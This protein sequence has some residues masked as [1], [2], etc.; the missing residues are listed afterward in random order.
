MIKLILR[1]TLL[2][3]MLV[4]GTAIANADTT[5]SYTTLGCFGLG[6]VPVALDSEPIAGPGSLVFAGVIIPAVV[7][8]PTGGF[9][10]AQLG[11]FTWVGT[12]NGAFITPFTLQIV[13]TLP[14]GGSD[15]F[16]ATVSG[17]V[18]SISGINSTTNVIFDFTSVT[19]GTVTYQLTNLGGPGTAGPTSLLINPPGQ[20]TTLQSIVTVNE[21]PEPASMLLLGT[22]LLGAAGAV[23]RRFKRN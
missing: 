10:G 5:V 6:C 23:R 20:T 22:G 12:P 21:V 4:A 14:T 15:I 11:T 8:I 9:S 17:T 18:Q 1:A 13:Q 2:S 7:D 3:A 16:T 19:I